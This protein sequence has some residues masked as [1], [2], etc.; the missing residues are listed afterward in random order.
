[1]IIST[2]SNPFAVERIHKIIAH[3]I[4][5]PKTENNWPTFYDFTSCHI[6]ACIN[7]KESWILI[8]YT[9]E[10]LILLNTLEISYKSIFNLYK[11]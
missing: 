5:K 4:D 10:I 1:M 6:C 8:N 3:K 11:C 7:E 2:A 9:Q